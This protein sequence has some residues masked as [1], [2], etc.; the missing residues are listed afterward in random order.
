MSF[1]R[2]G[3]CA[4]LLL[5]ACSTVPQ[6]T[7][8]ITV[9]KTQFSGEQ[10]SFEMGRLA[11]QN[12]LNQ[13]Q[14]PRHAKNVILFVG[15]GMGVSTVTGIRMYAGQQLGQP[16]EDYILA[17]ESLPHAA[18]SKTYNTNQ[19]V[20]DSAGT[21][22]A[23]MTGQKTKAGVIDVAPQIERNDCAGSLSAPLESLLIQ[24]ADH[25]YSTGIVSTA[26]LTHATP[27]ATY[28][29]SAN[30]DWESAKDLPET[31]IQEG[32]LSIASQMEAEMISG[33]L[34]IALGG[35]KGKFEL[36]VEDRVGGSYVGTKEALAEVNNDTKLPLLGLFSKSHM[37]F[38]RA[39]DETNHEPSLKD[40]TLT[41]IDRL[42]AENNGYFLMVEGGRIDHGH[43]AG[44]AELALTEGAAFDEAIAAA[45]RDVD[46]SETLII[47]TA[48][49][50]HTFNIAGYPTRGNPIL[51][52][53]RGNDDRGLPTGENVLASDGLPYTTLGYQN[54]PGAEEGTRDPST[55]PGEVIM[56][57]AA[58]PTGYSSNGEHHHSE[59]HGGEDVPI[60]AIGPSS[61]LVSGVMEENVIYHIMREAMGF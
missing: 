44:M 33:R 42:E 23:F 2:L 12:R 31:A 14:A 5:S 16:G 46:L 36:G 20:S 26:R 1:N 11:V 57:Q 22:T 49:H 47:V 39:K 7:G 54:G 52:T 61:D 17:M 15:D 37:E 32:C 13:P 55:K 38:V 29:H 43:H 35:G 28:S 8:P 9:P 41:A 40:M 6:A 4:L 24:A 10:G 53:V 58:I 19:Q 51:D 45:L 3:A 50:S 27:A 59:T 56:Q 21:A 34:D 30:R 48:D 25:G 18:L 60:F